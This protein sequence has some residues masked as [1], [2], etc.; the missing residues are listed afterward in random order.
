MSE[1]CSPNDRS[2]MCTRSKPAPASTGPQG[3]LVHDAPAA[4]LAA[5]DVHPSAGERRVEHAERSR[6]EA[7][8]VRPKAVSADDGE[9]VDEQ[10]ARFVEGLQPCGVEAQHPQRLVDRGT[11]RR[12]QQ[13]VVQQAALAEQNQLRQVR[14]DPVRVVVVDTLDEP[15][16]SSQPDGR[17]RSAQ[18]FTVRCTK[19]GLTEVECRAS[20]GEDAGNEVAAHRVVAVAGNPG[21]GDRRNERF[22]ADSLGDVP[23]RESPPALHARQLVARRHVARQ[24]IRGDRRGVHRLVALHAGG[25]AP[26]DVIVY[27]LSTDPAVPEPAR[28]RAAVDARRAQSLRSPL[29]RLHDTLPH[30]LVQ[31]APATR[32]G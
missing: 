29:R 5:A 30:D 4:R 7:H 21:P 3:V 6:Y 32:G 9:L 2:S 26:R 24:R 19:P 17:P 10:R 15:R 22:P 20:G 12:R 13:H 8:Q 11:P 18:H 16:G 31:D 25:A 27:R 28:R 23:E 14:R 1:T